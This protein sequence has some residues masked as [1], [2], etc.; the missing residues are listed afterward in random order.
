MKNRSNTA[1]PSKEQGGV[2]LQHEIVALPRDAAVVATVETVVEGAGVVIPGE[3]LRGR[4]RIDCQPT[5]HMKGQQQAVIGGL[6]CRTV[7]GAAIDALAPRASIKQA[8]VRSRRKGF[9][10]AREIG[11]RIPVDIC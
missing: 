3:D 6:P 7:I 1:L 5:T 4:D 9:P 8:A 10:I 11:V 2:V